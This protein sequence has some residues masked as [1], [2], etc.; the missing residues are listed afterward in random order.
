MMSDFLTCS[1][2]K[3]CPNTIRSFSGPYFPVFG[4]NLLSKSAYSVQMWKNTDQKNSLSGQ[5]LRSSICNVH[6]T[7]TN[8]KTF[9]IF[10]KRASNMSIE[11]SSAIK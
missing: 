6:K 2:H 5:F 3:K 9:L 7:F 4:L 1:L 8:L 10:K 11:Y